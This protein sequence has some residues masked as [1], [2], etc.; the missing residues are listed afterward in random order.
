[1]LMLYLL[2]QRSSYLKLIKYRLRGYKLINYLYL[3]LS[4]R[5]NLAMPLLRYDVYDLEH[6]KHRGQ[7]YLRTS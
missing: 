7:L 5:L 2:I 1:M 3:V 4:S 6:N